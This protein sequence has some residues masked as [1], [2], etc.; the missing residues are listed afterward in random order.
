MS[1]NIG[2][3]KANRILG[4]AWALVC[5][6]A[7][8]FQWQVGLGLLLIS[9]IGFSI[10]A[11]VVHRR[12]NMDNPEVDG[13]RKLK[14]YRGDLYTSKSMIFIDLGCKPDSRFR[15]LLVLVCLKVPLIHSWSAW[16]SL[17]SKIQTTFL[18]NSD[19]AFKKYLNQAIHQASQADPNYSVNLD[20]KHMFGQQYQLVKVRVATN[21]LT[22][23]LFLGNPDEMMS[24]VSVHIYDQKKASKLEFR[25]LGFDSERLERN[26]KFRL[27]EI[28][29][30]PHQLTQA[31]VVQANNAIFTN[32]DELD[33]PG[34][35][36]FS[37]NE[38]SRLFQLAPGLIER[39]V[40]LRSRDL[41]T[42]DDSSRE[43]AGFFARNTNGAIAYQR[44]ALPKD[45]CGGEEIFLGDLYFHRKAMASG[46]LDQA[47]VDVVVEGS[48][49]NSLEHISVEDVS[50]FKQNSV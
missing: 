45:W 48:P 10:V 30:R 2:S 43:I 20:A 1:W 35:V 11:V 5:V 49:Y 9:A 33:Y 19:G 46:K 15:D 29:S 25:L 18:E 34:L 4:A 22:R 47:V 26:R 42:L 41:S 3:K 27:H 24:L 39:I 14:T 7:G 28:F 37:L 12:H 23:R 32:D 21:G 16:M 50:T 17:R 13:F 38:R 36:L 44:I 8:L 31:V 6:I 40:G